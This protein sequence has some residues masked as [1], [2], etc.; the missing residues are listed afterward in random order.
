MWVVLR[1]LLFFSGGLGLVAGFAP[2]YLLA[3]GGGPHGFHLGSFRF[4]GVLP[5]ALGAAAAIWCAWDFGVTG[6]GTPAPLDPPKVLV[7]RG[8]YRLVRNPMFLGVGLILLGEAIVFESLKLLGYLGVLWVIANG[9]VLF[10]EEPHLKKTFGASY[11]EYRSR[12]PRW[13]PTL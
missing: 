11:E 2:Y 10:Y 12:V 8:L 13:M 6:K 3:S 1:S 4:A 9:F 5:M 7:T